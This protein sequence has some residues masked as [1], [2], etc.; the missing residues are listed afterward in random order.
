MVVPS[1]AVNVK[2]ALVDGVK[3]DGNGLDVT[4]TVGAVVSSVILTGDESAVAR[5]SVDSTQ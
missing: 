1:L 3:P 4:V 5:P 2:L